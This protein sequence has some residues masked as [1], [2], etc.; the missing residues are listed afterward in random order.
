MDLK[1]DHQ[2]W[3]CYLVECVDGSLYCG[4]TNDLPRRLQQHNGALQGGAKYTATRRPVNLKASWPHPNRSS[5][6]QHEYQIKKLKK[7]QKEKLIEG[8]EQTPFSD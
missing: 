3:W 6:S 7:L 8:F 5:A 2:A 4:V 1:D